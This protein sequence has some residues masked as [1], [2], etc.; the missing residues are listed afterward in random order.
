MKNTLFILAFL[1]IF[2]AL[3]FAQSDDSARRCGLP[4]ASYNYKISW[5][6]ERAQLSN[7]AYYLKNDS[8]LIGY[9][10]IFTKETASTARARFHAIQITKY[11]TKD[12]DP[13]FRIEKSRLVI[14]YKQTLDEPNIILQPV[15][16]GFPAPDF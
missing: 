14:I 9:I 6:D 7:F 16:K 11:L 15:A 8:A 3:S 4:F 5:N 1:L 12:I 13:D 2:S 10:F